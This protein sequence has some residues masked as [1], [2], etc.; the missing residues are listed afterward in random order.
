MPSRLLL[1]CCYLLLAR[2][3]LG[4]APALRPTA[5]RADSIIVAKTFPLL[6]LFEAQPAL[7]QVLRASAELQR[8]A[9]RQTRRSAPLLAQPV[10]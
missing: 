4:Q 8:V 6:A 3:S 5:A 2:P 10:A 7:R 9:Q 1:L